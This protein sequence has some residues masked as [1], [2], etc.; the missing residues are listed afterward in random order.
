MKNSELIEVL[1]ATKQNANEIAS[2]FGLEMPRHNVYNTFLGGYRFFDVIDESEK[3]IKIVVLS[4]QQ[5]IQHIVNHRFFTLEI[6]VPKS[7][8]VAAYNVR[9]ETSVSSYF[10]KFKKWWLLKNSLV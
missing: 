1:R 7:V 4:K 9:R 3:A 8:I 10:G 5:T 6:W 2:R